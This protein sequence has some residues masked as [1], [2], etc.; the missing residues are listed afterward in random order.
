M[1]DFEVVEIQESINFFEFNGEL[2][3][4]RDR[5]PLY[6]GVNQWD[7][8]G[9]WNA[10]QYIQNRPCWNYD[11][12]RATMLTWWWFNPSE[13]HNI[14]VCLMNSRYDQ[15]LVVC[16]LINLENSKKVLERKYL[17]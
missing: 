2:V 9:A 5:N 7:I 12:V 15:P 10:L 17:R 3:I 8:E 11:Q 16:R 4:K 14:K 6:F 13:I 1:Y